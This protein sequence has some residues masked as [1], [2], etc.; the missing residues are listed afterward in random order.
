[1]IPS[2]RSS[3]G[4]NGHFHLTG[5]CYRTRSPASAAHCRALQAVGVLTSDEAANI[6]IAL[7][8]FGKSVEEGASVVPSRVEAE[9]VHHFVELELTRVVGTLA[10][11]LHTGRSRNEQVATDLRLFIRSVI[12][13][14]T[15][16]L[17][18][19][20]SVLLEKAEAAG[21]AVMP[22]YTHLQRAEPV[23]VGHW[24]LAYVSMA[25]RDISRFS[26]C[27]ARLNRCP[28][29]S[30]AVAGATLPLDRMI[31]SSRPG[32]RWS[33]LEQHGCNQ[34]SRFCTRVC[35]GCVPSRTAP[36]SVR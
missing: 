27:R 15:Q 34:R 35:P 1:M 11:K 4:G 25:E 10:L 8:E 32:L 28:L 12:E 2:T 17:G 36:F 33:Y 13:S 26:D 7:Q 24:L 29:G 14:A 9:D 19:W 20:I 31:A 30:G 21:T 5:D 18:D 6:E 16:Y 3:K 22:S 23:L